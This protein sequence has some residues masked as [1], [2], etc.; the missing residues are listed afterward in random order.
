MELLHE[1]AKKELI[2][3][4]ASYDVRIVKNDLGLDLTES[5]IADAMLLKHTV[6]EEGEFS[7]KGCAILY[8]D[9][10]G[11]DM[12][13]EANAEQIELKENVAKNG[14]STTKDNYEMFKADLPIMGKYACFA[15]KSSLVSIKDGS[16][17]FIED[18]NVGDYV[19]TH[20]GRSKRVYATNK[21][22]HKGCIYNITL[23]GGRKI[24]NVTD[25]HPFY[26]LDEKT[27]EYKWVKIK[28]IKTNDILVKG[29]R[30]KNNSN[31]QIHRYSNFWWLFGLYQAD[32]YVRLQNNTKYPVYTIH[33]EEL[34]YLQ[35]ILEDSNLKY[36]VIEKK[37]SKAVD[38]VIP[39]S[40]LGQLFINMSGGKFKCHEKRLSESTFYHLNNHRGDFLNF[41]SGVLDGDGHFR[42]L[43]S[44][45]NSYQLS[46][47]LTSES[48]INTLDLLCNSHEIQATRGDYKSTGNRKHRYSLKFFGYTCSIINKYLNIKHKDDLPK[49]T[50][51]SYSKL[52]RVKK[53]EVSNF[54]DYVYNISVEGD[55]TYISNGIITHNCA[56]ADLTL[57]LAEVFRGI[58][59]S[60]GLEEFFY[61]DEVMPLYKYVT[62]P[63]ED[64]GVKL[65]LDLI[66]KTKEEIVVDI[67]KLESQ[68]KESI[69]SDSVVYN[70][71]KAKAIEKFPASNKGN[72][73]QE[74]IR[75]FDL[76]L[77]ISE[78]TGKYMMGKKVLNGLP[79]SE[80]K[81][82]LE[83]ELDA[84]PT[85]LLE[86]VSLA[87]WENSNDGLINISSK[88]QMGE[89]AF[90]YLGIK[91]LS[92][93]KG[94]SPQFDDTMIQHLG[95]K[96][97][98]EWAKLLGDYNKLIKI[99]G[100]YIDRFLDGHEDGFY[101]FYYKQHGTISGR[102]SSDAQQ[103]PRPKEEGELSPLVLRYNNLVRSFFIAEEGR[104]FIDADYESLEP[105]VFA[106][107]SEDDNIRDIFRK[108]H[109]FYST[110][111]IQAE[112]LEGVSADKKAPNYLKIV[113]SVKRQNA[114]P[115]SLGI[116]YGMTVFALKMALGISQKEA[117]VIH[118][119][120]WNGFQVLHQKCKDTWIEAQQYGLVKT[121]V[122]RARHL[123]KCKAL[124]AKHGDQLL[125]WKYRK[126]LERKLQSSGKYNRQEA[127]DAVK[128]A[129]R[130]Y[131]NEKNN[132]F[133]FKIQGLSAS[134]VNR[135]AMAVTEEFK[136]RNINAWVCAQVHDQLLFNCPQDRL[137]EC[138]EIVK[139]KMEN[140]T[141]LS[142]T[143]KA[144]PEVTYNWKDGH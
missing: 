29:S 102:Y 109:D 144:P 27:L 8:Q 128:T 59:E 74:I 121:E 60:E 123:T 106:H 35:N 77:P 117:A 120:Y 141:K 112:G 14:G 71:I 62:I 98:I 63:M 83:G 85:E 132:S 23:E 124:Y 125:D 95:D 26:V 17:K 24:K 61:D 6:A 76:D 133:N 40:D 142:L 126:S 140:T 97:D 58:L 2:M 44:K 33:Q 110:I 143:L 86:E 37:G 81:M 53:V 21:R 47:E 84:L 18:V 122:G 116:P 45:T 72:F 41:L 88:T 4:N 57:R 100:S 32:G 50:E 119:G 96:L 1:I 25:E 46:L 137:E 5:L 39:N 131:K 111:A 13:S 7:L 80:V 70:G 51:H 55:E 93:T 114:K 113:D 90:N 138:L 91:P 127:I 68:V 89:I 75:R 19:I 69:L 34:P 30:L 99:R 67:A 43:K 105:H 54:S 108:G 78:K 3:W 136:A 65:D 135:A 22:K 104:V 66:N 16:C 20:K 82:F 48:L 42:K 130:D 10:L 129:Y 38:V 49:F 31:A 64:K 94:G 115:Y 103:L 56:D 107:V 101:Y 36:S 11:L 87:L 12:E 79:F 73:A 139:D 15:E 9:K 52:V 92:K 118:S 134:I 28:D